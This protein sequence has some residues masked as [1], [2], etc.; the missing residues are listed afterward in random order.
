MAF[1][2]VQVCLETT[3]S[4]PR[5]LSN[6]IKSSPVSMCW[7]SLVIFLIVRYCY[8]FDRFEPGADRVYRIVSVGITF[9]IAMP[10]SW[11][12][13]HSRLHNFAFQTS[14][15]WWMF[16]LC[17]LVM[18]LIALATNSIQTFRAASAN[19]VKSLRTE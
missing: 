8:S 4:S 1:A 3:C 10:L 16:P 13:T 11:W 6:V 17:G 15:G 12:A 14:T 9:A 18:A 5:A 19:P 7:G 2:A